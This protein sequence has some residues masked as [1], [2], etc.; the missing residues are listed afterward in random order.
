MTFSDDELLEITMLYGTAVAK[1]FSRGVVRIVKQFNDQG[2]E[3]KGK[4]WLAVID[5]DSLFA[6]VDQYQTVMCIRHKDIDSTFDTIA[7]GD[8]KVALE[9]YDDPFFGF[10]VRYVD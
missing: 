3:Y 5:D 4:F 1:K 7:N 9:I 6:L 10:K 2:L 8:D